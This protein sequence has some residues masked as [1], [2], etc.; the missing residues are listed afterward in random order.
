MDHQLNQNNEQKKTIYYDGSCP[1][2]TIIINKVDNSSQKGKFKPKDITREL[3]P[4][5]F[6]KE[7]VEKEIHVIDSEG[8][9]YKNA[10]AILKIL[11]EYPRWKFLAIIGRLPI[12]K[13][14]LPIGYKFIAANRYFIFGQASRIFWLKIV[15]IGGLIAGL[16]LSVKLW[17]DGRFFPL[18]PI[19]D[20][21]LIV[22]PPVETILFIIL[23]GLLAAIFIFPKPKKLIF[24]ALVV[25]AIFAFFDQMR[26]QPWFYQ[27]FFMLAT[28]GLF[29]WNYADTEKRQAVLNT[30]R[31]VVASIYFF[32]G[33]Q[34]VNPAFMDGQSLWIIEPVAKFF[35]ISLHIFMLSL[36]KIIPFLEMGIGIGLL[37]KK[38]RKYF[39]ILALL[40]HI[41]ILFILG[42]L[43]YNWNSIVWPWNIAMGFFVVILFWRTD[44]FSFRDIFWVKNFPL[45]KVIFVLFGFMPVLSFF[46]LWD[47]YLSSTLYSRN[48]NSAQIYI[49]DSVKKKMPIEVQRYTS[50]AGENVNTLHFFNWSL[51]ELNVP[52][53]PETR[54]YKDIARSI[55]KYADKNNDVILVV[56]GKPTLFNEGHRSIYNCHDL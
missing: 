48:T 45:Q 32:S 35:P 53:Y 9:I 8:R 10:E 42:P 49:S 15:V 13:Q 37:T 20:D 23:L 40:M 39:V 6:T 2:C 18:A 24:S 52:T 12:I 29:S 4:Q 11:E 26:W 16:L 54:V 44:N 46:N 56:N 3:L 55:C 51:D 31:L 41:F 5:N 1:M 21:F 50:Q 30:N 47:S 34:K 28:L 17:T 25:A 38:C 33:L 19:L 14:L 36:D 7:Q 43:G 27:Y 22:S